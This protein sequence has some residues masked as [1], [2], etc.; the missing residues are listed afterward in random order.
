MRPNRPSCPVSSNTDTREPD[1]HTWGDSSGCPDF[2]AQPLLHETR[3]RPMLICSER[4]GDPRYGHTM[5][6]LCTQLQTFYNTSHK[7]PNTSTAAWT[8]KA[9]NSNNHEDIFPRRQTACRLKI[10][11]LCKSLLR[12]FA[13]SPAV[14]SLP[15]QK[16]PINPFTHAR[17]R[18]ESIT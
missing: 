13:F 5:C 14:A 9:D 16:Q 15:G 6:Q 17:Q 10:F 3:L 7:A 18:R 4:H 1:L 8:Q 11:R 12:S 2:S